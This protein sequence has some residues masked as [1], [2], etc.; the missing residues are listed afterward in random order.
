IEPGYQ[1]QAVI[2]IAEAQPAREYVAPT[3]AE[4]VGER[5]KSL[6]LAVMARPIVFEAGKELDLVRG[7]KKP[8]GLVDRMRARMDVKVEGED[9]FLLTYAD[10]NPERARA[11]VNKMSELFIKRHVEQRQELAGATVTALQSE[12][13]ALWPELVDAEKAVRDYK[14]KHY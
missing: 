2:R 8:D 4:Q 12:V 6:R 11:V 5:L 14:L 3:V 1:A 10:A 7:V 13:G 9:T